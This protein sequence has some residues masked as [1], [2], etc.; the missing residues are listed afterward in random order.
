LSDERIPFAKIKAVF[1]D[2]GGTLFR[3][4]PSV[5]EVYSEVARA[6][7]LETDPAKLE[8]IF[9]SLW[10]KRDG[11]ASLASHSSE[12]EEK[13][14]WHSLV[15]EVFSSLGTVENFDA[16][17]DEL[18]D[19]F[20]SPETWCLFEDALPALREMK[21]SK[22]IVGI[23]SNWDSRLFRICKGLGL[24]PY[25]DFILASAVVGAAKPSPKIFQE[26]LRRAGVQ[27]EEAIHVGDSLE[28]DIRGAEQA[29][30]RAVFLDRQG[31][32]TSQTLKISTLQAIMQIFGDTTTD[33][34]WQ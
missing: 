23:V 1:F 15:W 33:R 20:A 29:G 28:D 32:R 18:Y 31:T 14:W 26:A 12:K 34:R 9:H 2:A 10:E 3:P 5:G 30:I 27:P 22:K 17:F 24:E 13:N 4:Y 7:G 6:H 8:S 19:R 11:L 21:K 16:F 25:L